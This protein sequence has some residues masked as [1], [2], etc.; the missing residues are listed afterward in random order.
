MAT[1]SGRGRGGGRLWSLPGAMRR[2]RF[3]TRRKGSR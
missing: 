3:W 1:R 2:D